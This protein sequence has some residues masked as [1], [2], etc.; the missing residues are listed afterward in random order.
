MGAKVVTHQTTFRYGRDELQTRPFL[1]HRRKRRG[2]QN[3]SSEIQ[4]TKQFV[5]WIAI[6]LVFINHRIDFNS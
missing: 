1:Y 4:N 5:I 6:F 3:K 2:R